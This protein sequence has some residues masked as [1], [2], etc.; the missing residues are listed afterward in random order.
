MQMTKHNRSGAAPDDVRQIEKHQM[1]EQPTNKNKEKAHAETK[2][3]CDQL[4]IHIQ[5]N[6]TELDLVKHHRLL[7]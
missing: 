5:E 6:F 7:L 4:L 1:K 2:I 3:I